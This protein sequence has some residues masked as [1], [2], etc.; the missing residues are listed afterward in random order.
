MQEQNGWI[1]LSDSRQSKTAQRWLHAP[2]GWRVT[3]CGHMT[4]NWP[5]Y[6]TDPAHEARAV[7]SFNGLGFVSLRAAVEVVEQLACG[8]LIATNDNCTP[9]VRRVLV[10]CDG[11]SIPAAPGAAHA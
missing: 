8:R 7:V 2:S 9:N 5:Y 6:L 4:A 1:R 11:S 10:V 3:H